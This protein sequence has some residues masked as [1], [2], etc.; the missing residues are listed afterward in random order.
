MG[1]A[2]PSLRACVEPGPRVSTEAARTGPCIPQAGCTPLHPRALS[3]QLLKKDPSPLLPP[4]LP[5]PCRAP[6]HPHV[7][8][9]AGRAHSH[10]RP[11]PSSGSGS[12]AFPLS[13]GSS[14]HSPCSSTHTLY[15]TYMYSVL[16]I[17]PFFSGN[18]RTAQRG[19]GCYKNVSQGN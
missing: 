4:G 16:H 15:I 19:S 1:P 13:P 9:T 5:E 10:S 11:P 12:A 18:D 3:S 6:R 17:F 7:C 14:P 2:S 8:W